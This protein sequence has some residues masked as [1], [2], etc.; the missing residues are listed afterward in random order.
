MVFDRFLIA[1][2]VPVGS[3][4]TAKR[5]RVS[6]RFRVA[7]ALAVLSET[8]PLTLT[9]SMKLSKK[10]RRIHLHSSALVSV[11]PSE[12]EPVSFFDI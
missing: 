8:L 7:V 11:F 5:L 6:A 9:T 12:S 4:R 1:T 10:S 2:A 3:V